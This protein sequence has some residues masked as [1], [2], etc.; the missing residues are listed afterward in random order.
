M[1]FFRNFDCS[2]SHNSINFDFPL[3]LKHLNCTFSTNFDEILKVNVKNFKIFWFFYNFHQLKILIFSAIYSIHPNF[4][5]S[6]NYKRKS[7]TQLFLMNFEGKSQ[8][9]NNFWFILTLLYTLYRKTSSR[10]GELILPKTRNSQNLKFCLL[11]GWLNWSK[12]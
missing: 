8:K 6:C 12:T 4:L 2:S 11:G 10:G 7:S 1:W 5:H 3:N 9:F